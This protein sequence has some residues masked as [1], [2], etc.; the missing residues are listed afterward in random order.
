MRF[1]TFL[2]VPLI[3]TVAAGCEKSPRDKLQG[4]WVGESAQ[5]VHPSQASQASGWAKGTRLEFAGNKVTV[6]IP[7][8]SPR[9]GTFKIDKSQGNDLDV[10][11][12]RTGGGEDHAKLALAD[13]GKLVWT[14]GGGVQL[15]MR[16][17]N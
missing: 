16:R 3:G 8:E 4:K 13:D 2:I 6:A 14:L 12:K 17:E 7:A 11:F 5:E 9:T 10:T 1:P 15:V